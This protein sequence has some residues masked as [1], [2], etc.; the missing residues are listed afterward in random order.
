MPKIAIFPVPVEAAVCRGGRCYARP[1]SHRL[2]NPQAV[3]L[4]RLLGGNCLQQRALELGGGFF[5]Q[6]F[7]IVHVELRT[8]V[9]F[10][11]S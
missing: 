4:T 6:A 5:Q 10:S 1:K 11:L 9:F 7:G 8:V 3:I 2:A